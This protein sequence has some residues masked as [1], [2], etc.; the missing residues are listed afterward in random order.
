MAKIGDARP[1][2]V[3][4]AREPMPP[5]QPFTALDA[6]AAEEVNENAEVAAKVEAQQDARAA[7]DAEAS[8][9]SWREALVVG[10][11]FLASMFPRAR[12]VWSD[13]WMDREAAALARCFPEGAGPLFANPWFG[14]AI[15]TAPTAISVAR[16]VKE[17]LDAAEAKRK[18]DKLR[19]GAGNATDV[20]ARSTGGMGAVKG[21]VPFGG[22]GAGQR[23]Q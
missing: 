8:A 4:D 13:E 20:Q 11:D 14:L 15:V 10:G 17:D 1:E 7:A 23:T 12:A 9:Q 19:H 16:I 6:I 21:E 18:L 2:V 3:Q 22:D 5:A